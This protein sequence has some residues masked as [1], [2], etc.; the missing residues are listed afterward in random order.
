MIEQETQ[1]PFCLWRCETLHILVRQNLP[2]SQGCK[3]PAFERLHQLAI[4]PHIGILVNVSFFEK[5]CFS[6]TVD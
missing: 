2:A 5:G 3:N 4:C 1:L 6:T